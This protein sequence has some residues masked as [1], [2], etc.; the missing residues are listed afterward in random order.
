MSVLSQGFWNNE[1]FLK[2]WDKYSK[3]LCQE[4]VYNSKYLLDIRKLLSEKPY[5]EIY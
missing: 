3:H 2:Y 1:A 5:A 4:E